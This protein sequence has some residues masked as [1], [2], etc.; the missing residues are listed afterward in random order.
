MGDVSLE[1]VEEMF[2]IARLMKEE[3]SCTNDQFHVSML[4][5]QALRFLDRNPGSTMSD[6]A[7]HFLI[8]LPSA[9]SLA[10]RLVGDGWVRR[11]E[12]PDDRRVVKLALTEKGQT[13]LRTGM[14]R[15]RKKLAEILSYLSDGEKSDLLAILRVLSGKLR[16]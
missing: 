15:H 1:L 16:K 4:Q 6:L 13:M 10:N 7:K 12:D 11:Q 3:M 14:D 2:A 5:I 9:T 8:E